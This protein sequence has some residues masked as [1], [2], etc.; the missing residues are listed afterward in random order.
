MKMIPTAEAEGHVLC[1]DITEI[2]RGVRKGARFLKGHIITAADIPVLLSLGKDNIY[3]WEND[4]S[5]LH[6]NDAAKILCRLCQNEKMTASAPREGKIDL[7]AE[8]DG[9]LKVDVTRLNAINSLDEIIIATRHNNTPV[10]KGDKLAGTRIIPLLIKKEKMA[11]AE[12][13]AGVKPLLELL[14]YKK[15]TVGVIT[16]GSEVFYGRIADTFT[17]VIAEKLARYGLKI[18]EHR[19]VDDNKENIGAAIKELLKKNIDLILC[20]GGMSVDPDDRTP[21]AIRDVGA[22]IVTYGVPVLPGAMF[23]LAYFR[24]NDKRVPVM[25]LPGCVMYARTTV[26]DLVLPRI[27]AGDNVAKADLQQLGNGGLCL[28][29]ADCHYPN[30]SFGKGL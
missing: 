21:A 20:T 1:H 17:P 8:I 26:F 2:V 11:R 22:E 28:E 3:V 19:L 30:C 10:K 7:M 27:I 18:D 29:C 23:L 5:L 6:E 4:A 9:V 25:G 12:K 13:F 16:T 14:P 24:H 15:M